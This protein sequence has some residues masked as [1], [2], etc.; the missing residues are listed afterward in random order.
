MQQSA[1]VTI[2]HNVRRHHPIT[3]TETTQRHNDK[4]NPTF[5][6]LLRTYLGQSESNRFN[7]NCIWQ[8][9]KAAGYSRQ[10]RNAT[11]ISRFWFKIRSTNSMFRPAYL[12]LLCAIS[13]HSPCG[14]HAFLESLLN[15]VQKNL[16]TQWERLRDQQTRPRLMAQMHL[17]GS[18]TFVEVGDNDT[19][20][21]YFFETF[22]CKVFLTNL[23]HFIFCLLKRRVLRESAHLIQNFSQPHI[24]LILISHNYFDMSKTTNIKL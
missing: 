22:F 12:L 6:I 15:R 10:R 17:D 9:T 1:R 16:M 7:A 3:W 4:T 13:L 19:T 2:G 18:P 5:Y 8:A 20:W 21:Y 23:C 24:I 11:N 14:S